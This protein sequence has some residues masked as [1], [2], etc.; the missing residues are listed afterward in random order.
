MK[1]INPKSSESPFPLLI[2]DAKIK[3]GFFLQI[4]KP[5]GL[6]IR[7]PFIFARWGSA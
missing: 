6:Y 2:I 1:I 7:L 4:N 5:F 3:F